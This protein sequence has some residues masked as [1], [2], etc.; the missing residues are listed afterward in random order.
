MENC[1]GNMETSKVTMKRI[2]MAS[3]IQKK[4][5]EA[6]ARIRIYRSNRD[7]MRAF[8]VK[9]PLSSN[10]TGVVGGLTA[11]GVV[12][13]AIASFA[14]TD[15]PITR[16]DP[17]VIPKPAPAPAVIK[18]PEP[19][20]AATLI[21]GEPTP[22]IV[23]AEP[24]N[25]S[26]TND[27]SIEP[28]IFFIPPPAESLTPP[29]KSS[30]YTIAVDKSRRELFVLAETEDS[31]TIVKRFTAE[32]G[33][34]P[35]D[36]MEANDKKTPEGLYRIVSIREGDGLPSRYGPR[37]YVLNYP[38]DLDE[39]MG[40]SGFGI[41]IHGSGMGEKTEPTKGCVE[42]NDHNIL[43]LGEYAKVGTPVYIFPESFEI[44]TDG[45]EISKNMIHPDTLY[46]LKEWGKEFNFLSS[47]RLAV[48]R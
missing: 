37:A 45:N 25:L 20:M 6:K 2:K 3:P 9:N 30:R 41:W 28:E 27:I 26:V 44:P 23:E 14:I 33:I 40:K 48:A 35:G 34:K 38:N 13:F 11:C 12:F 46:A 29:D 15:F 19:E 32:L 8:K 4:I 18:I 17:P 43:D 1:V 24:E 39:K 10:N 16:M 42:I 36:K 47:Q 5:I 22:V 31:F 21:T 7:V